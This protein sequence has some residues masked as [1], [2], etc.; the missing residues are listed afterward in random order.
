MSKFRPSS[1]LLFLSAGFGLFTATPLLASSLHVRKSAVYKKLSKDLAPTRKSLLFDQDFDKK[2]VRPLI[3]DKLVEKIIALEYAHQESVS[4]EIAAASV[5]PALAIK[6]APVSRENEV[7]SSIPATETEKLAVVLEQAAPAIE[8]AVVPQT[9]P[10]EKDLIAFIEKPKA[11]AVPVVAEE[12]PAPEQKVEATKKL[13][14]REVILPKDLNSH[15]ASI[16]VLDEETYSS[17]KF[18][19]VPGAK[20]FWLHPDSSLSSIVSE[21]GLVK[22]PYPKAI[23]TRFVVVADGYLPAV[24]YSVKGQVTPVLLYKEK[25]LPPILK[26]LHIQPDSR[27]SIL[28]GRF[29]DRDLKPIAHMEFETFESQARRNFFSVGSF[30]LFHE[31]A[32]ESGPQG[33][34]L[35]SGL[36][37]TLQYLL[38]SRKNNDHTISEW[39]AQILDLKGL[40]TV[41][42]NTIVSSRP[43][44]LETQVVDAYTLVKPDTGIFASVGGQRGLTE[45]DKNGFLK[46]DDLYKRPNVDLIEISAQGYLKTWI[47]SPI[48]QASMPDLVPLFTPGQASE[49]LAPVDE[50]IGRNDSLVAGTLRPEIYNYETQILVYN[51]YGKRVREAKIF[52]FGKDGRVSTNVKSIDPADAR[53]MVTG[54]SEGEFHFVLIN[55]ETGI[56]QSIQVVRVSDGVVSQVQF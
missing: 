6:E 16:A 53:F 43:M 3:S 7:V 38:S 44:D 46:F 42:T 56:G 20:V 50:K 45:P 36:D 5:A 18:V 17:G 9:M 52:Y 51:S 15:R 22:V 1:S 26:S 24:G 25:R 32:K 10:V 40:G 55:A 29:L 41:L 35:F 54:L 31:A 30:G 27:E 33:D 48:D 12:K 28:I 23:S 34:F 14:P 13:S 37:H 21:S 11:E 47:N 2:T 19:S 4:R 39:P 49:I 8:E